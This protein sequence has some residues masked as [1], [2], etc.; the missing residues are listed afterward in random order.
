M[1]EHGV[2]PERRQGRLAPKW[3]VLISVVFG[4]FMVI[5]DTTVVNVAFRT[6]QEE[7]HASVD[8]SQWIISMYVMA[9]GIAT[10]VSGYLADR[11]GMKRIFLTGL[12]LFTTGSLLCG[13][14]PQ[15]W[16]L[17]AAR[18]L[19]GI[20]GGIALPL[21]SAFLFSTFPRNEQGKAL[22]IFGI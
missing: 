15:L 7:F 13:V 12:A 22:G 11:F 5:L 8:Q 16:T 18:V 4:L 9:L 21:G 2:T 1:V 10:P 14:A 19:Q 20:G 3:R 6:L 17:V